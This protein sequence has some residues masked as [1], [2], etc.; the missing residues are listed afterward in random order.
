MDKESI[1][2][3]IIN[4]VR[5]HGTLKEPFTAKDVR[6]IAGGWSYCRYFSYMAY[7]CTENRPDA[8]ALFVRV[9]RGKYKLSEN[10]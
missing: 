9:A 6:R 4:A 3:L 5:V 8:E 10:K 7:N 2:P 1:Y